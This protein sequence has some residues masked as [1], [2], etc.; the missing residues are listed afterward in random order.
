[1]DTFQRLFV[2]FG[3]TLYFRGQD[4]AGIELWKTDG[5]PEGT[6]LVEDIHPGAQWSVPVYLAPL[7]GRVYFSADDKYTPELLAF[8]RELW[9]TDGTSRGTFRVKDIHPGPLPSIPGELTRLN[10]V[11]LF[12]AGEP[13]GGQELWR[14]DGSEDGTV[15]V[16]DINPGP[17]GSFPS[18]F[19]AAIHNVYFAADDGA[20]GRELWRSDGTSPGTVRVKDISPAGA[21]SGPLELTEFGNGLLFTS[22]DGDHG[23]ELWYTDGTESGTQL[24]MDIVPGP[25]SSTPQSLTVA[26]DDVYFTISKDFDPHDF[27]GVTELWKTDG[28]SAGT[29]MVWQAPGRFRGPSIRELTAARHH[30]FLVAPTA[31]DSQ[32]QSADFEPHAVELHPSGGR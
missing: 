22:D 2:P 13:R 23:R 30:L 31:V 15:R 3:D 14:S 20:S 5:T 10:E 8:D 9:T 19:R 27:T 12:T 25:G 21:F 11:I 17:Q 4:L 26:G 7:R 28:T 29:H 18:N 24:V 1:V 32:G 16:R 6:V